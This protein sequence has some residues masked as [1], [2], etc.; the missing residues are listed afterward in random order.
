MRNGLKLV[1]AVIVVALYTLIPYFAGR[2]LNAPAFF[3]QTFAG[4]PLSAC[5]VGLM[6]A[7]FPI[8]CWISSL[9]AT[10]DANSDLDRE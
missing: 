1:V 3:Q 2:P 6:L 4:V 5:F 8:I 7:T 9:M 10:A